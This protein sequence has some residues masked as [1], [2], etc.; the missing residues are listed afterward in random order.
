MKARGA[1]RQNGEVTNATLTLGFDNL[2]TIVNGLP[3]DRIDM[4]PF[5]KVF[6]DEK[7]LGSQAKIGFIPFTRNCLGNKKVRH[8]LGQHVVDVDLENLQEKYDGLVEKAELKG[9][10]P[11]VFDGAIPVAEHVQQVGEPE[12]SLLTP[13]NE[14]RFSASSLWNICSSRLSNSGVT[15]RAQTEQLALDEA[16]VAKAI[17]EKEDKKAKLL[18]KAQTAC[19]EVSH[20]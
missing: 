16:K 18:A 15:L 8:E 14:R 1:A 6:T 19:S 20:E 10:N 7:I 17:H 4:R 5:D 11:G 12:R 13:G 3:A 9:F 2:S